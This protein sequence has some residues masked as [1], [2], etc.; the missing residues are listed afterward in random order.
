[1]TAGN[2]HEFSAGHAAI[3]LPS[4]RS[5]GIVFAAAFSIYAIHLARHGNILW[6]VSGFAALIIAIEGFRNAAW[7]T[8]LNKLWM[9]FGLLLSMI[10]APIAL[11]ILFFVVV[12]PM[13]LIARAIGKDF[14]HLR[15]DTTKASYW[16]YREPPGPDAESMN[17]Q[18]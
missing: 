3:E 13:A 16:T 1:M 12:A 15:R 17:R 6:V 8:P 4:N 7:L 11:G 5:F 10:I 2:H 18:F 9:K 14:L